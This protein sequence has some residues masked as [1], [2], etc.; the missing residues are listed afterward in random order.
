M[1]LTT[2]GRFAVT[3]MAD[4]AMRDQHGP[5]TY[6]GQGDRPMLIPHRQI[7]HGCH[8]KPPLGRKSHNFSW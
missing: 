1:R 4:L 8:G 3:A 2:K 6:I 7:S 5:F